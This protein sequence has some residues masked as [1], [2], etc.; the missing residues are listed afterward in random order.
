VAWHSAPAVA[1]AWLLRPVPATYSAADGLHDLTISLHPQDT[2][3]G[4]NEGM[5]G[6]AGLC[7]AMLGYAGLCWAMLGYAGL[8]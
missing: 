8:S 6:Y 4:I 2:A 1:L 7:W 3:Q 5:L